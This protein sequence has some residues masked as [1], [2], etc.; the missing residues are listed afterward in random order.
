LNLLLTSGTVLLMPKAKATKEPPDEPGTWIFRDV[1][2]NL[3]RRAKA[4]AAI[5]GT[6]VRQLT[7]DLMEA[8]LKEL[9]RKGIL[10][11]GKG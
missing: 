9:D 6:S 7:I 11:K 5:Q 8:H 2:R 4:A 10:P 3:M 1:P